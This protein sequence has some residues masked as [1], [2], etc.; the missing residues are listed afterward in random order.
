MTNIYNQGQQHLSMY[1]YNKFQNQRKWIGE[2]SSIF[3]GGKEK[4]INDSEQI[5]YP[6]PEHLFF[7]FTKI[8]FLRFVEFKMSDLPMH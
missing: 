5:N 8:Y 6:S 4:K 2:K 1:K 3:W 7:I